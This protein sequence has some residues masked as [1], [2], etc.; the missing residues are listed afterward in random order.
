MYGTYDANA[1]RGGNMVPGTQMPQARPALE[2]VQPQAMDPRMN[3][4]TLS[5]I[6]ALRN[7]QQQPA[8]PADQPAGGYTAPQGTPGFGLGQPVVSGGFGNAQYA[9]GAPLHHP[10][11]LGLV[12][13]SNSYRRIAG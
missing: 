12:L 10:Q 8:A 9:G 13:V 7:K 3:Q 6:M 1:L 11:L 2:Q 5:M 4:S